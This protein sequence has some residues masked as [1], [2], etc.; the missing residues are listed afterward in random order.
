MQLQSISQ[1]LNTTFRV[2][3]VHDFPNAW[4]G[5]Q[6]EN[7][8]EVTKIAGA[9]D[10]N[11]QAIEQAIQLKA[12][13]LCVHHGLHWQGVQPLVGP[14][15][16]LYSKAIQA[17]LAVYSLHLPLDIHPQYSHNALLAKLLDIDVKDTFCA[18]RD[19]PCGLLGFKECTRDELSAQLQYHFPHY[20]TLCYGSEQLD[21]IGIVC[22]SGGQALLDELVEKN[23]S[24][25]ITGEIHYSAVS[26]AQLHHLNIF[27]CG[28]YA[29]EC[30]G[31]QA[32]LQLLHQQFDLPCQFLEQG[33]VL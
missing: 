12:D 6:L 21:N 20:H 11:V 33:C 2:D 15:Y 10:A 22:G 5:L 23:F 1:F 29:T 30:F 8:G 16:E 18:Y 3:S 32:L 9:V 17:N 4:N 13:L 27:A 26:F 25:L 7:N 24:T 19:Q 31:I 14:V 28:H